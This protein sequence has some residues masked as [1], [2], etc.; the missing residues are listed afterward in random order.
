MKKSFLIFVA[1]IF[2][3]HVFAQE[4][5]SPS[6]NPSPSNQNNPPPKDRRAAKRERINNLIKMEEEGDLIFHKH[7]LFGIKLATDGYGIFYERGKFQ[8]VNRTFLLQFELNEKKDPKDHKVATGYFNGYSFNSVVIGKLNNFYQFKVSAG[9]QFLIGGKGNKNGVAVSALYTGGFSLG[10]LK[11]YLYDVSKPD[12]NVTRLKYPQII[13]SGFTMG[14]T[15]ASGFT[16]GWNQAQFKP[17]LNLKTALRFDYGRYNQSITAIETGIS[18]EY[19][20]MEIPMMY[21]VPQKHL[22]FNAYVTIMF[23][24]RK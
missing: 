17:G 5:P 12:G 20:F 10:I 11:P 19:Y 6:E 14:I 1:W 3:M 13:D 4:T 15:G 23:G 24:R 7:G 18:L 22:F 16:V 2:S 8:T 21:L 9:H